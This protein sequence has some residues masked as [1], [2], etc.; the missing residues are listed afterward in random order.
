M[1]VNEEDWQAVFLSDGQIYFG[2]VVG[3]TEDTVFLENIFY[4]KEKGSL[5]QGENNFNEQKKDVSLIKLGTELH[6]PTDRMRL[7]KEQIMFIEDLQNDSKIV[8]AILN[9]SGQ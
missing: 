3:E 8:R 2:K 5:H 4:M 9:Y 7:N 6:K 1:S